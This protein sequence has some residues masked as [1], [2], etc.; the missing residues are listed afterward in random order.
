MGFYSAPYDAQG[1]FYFAPYVKIL[2]ESH[3][4]AP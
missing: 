2:Q 4:K 3:K 1:F